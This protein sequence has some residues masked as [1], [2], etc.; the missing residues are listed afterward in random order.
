MW[1]LKVSRDSKGRSEGKGEVNRIDR[2]HP[3]SPAVK[4]DGVW[5]ADA[6]LVALARILPL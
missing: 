2:R 1:A 4:L 5:G 3:Q 6:V